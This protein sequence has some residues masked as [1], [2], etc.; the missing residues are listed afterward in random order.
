MKYRTERHMESPFVQQD[1]ARP[2]LR[3][4]PNTQHMNKVAIAPNPIAL[5]HRIVNDLARLA[6]G[7]TE[8]LEGLHQYCTKPRLILVVRATGLFLRCAIFG[9][10]RN[11]KYRNI[12]VG[13]GIVDWAVRTSRTG[14]LELSHRFLKIIYGALRHL[15]G[16]ETYFAE[17]RVGA[18]FGV[19]ETYYYFSIT[20]QLAAHRGIPAFAFRG[21]QRAR[22]DLFSMQ[23]MACCG[24]FETY[25]TSSIELTD[26][27]V[28]KELNRLDQIV[29]GLDKYEYMPE[30]SDLPSLPAT[31][32]YPLLSSPELYVVYLH[33]FYDAIG[34]YGDAIFDDHFQWADFVL[35]ILTDR[36]L[37]VVVK[38]HPNARPEN[39]VPIEHL[40]RKYGKKALFCEGVSTAELFQCSISCIFTV[41]GSIILEAARMGITTITAGRHPYCAFPISIN[42]KTTEELRRSIDWVRRG[43][44]LTVNQRDVARANYSHYGQL[45][46][47]EYDIPMTDL[48]P[49]DWVICFPNSPYPRH[50]YERLLHVFPSEIVYDLAARRLNKYSEKIFEKMRRTGDE[51]S[52]RQ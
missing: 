22:I 12:L 27:Q 36:K 23:T 28:A 45:N 3:H 34:A 7:N 21:G 51:L 4:L 6:F 15:H 47:D 24:A 35:S 33:D 19:D 39:R 30:K 26:E 13:P 17:N 25:A 1:E 8:P 50:N 44:R 14:R 16:A 49:D 20:A 37:N 52:N 2:A 31:S 41:Y 42:P 10:A 48:S 40:K 9:K 18:V 11:L 38:S 5:D 43:G 29:R 46:N 32:R